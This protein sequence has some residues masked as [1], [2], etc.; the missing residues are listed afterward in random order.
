MKKLTIAVNPGDHDIGDVGYKVD[1][2]LKSCGL[3]NET[4]RAQ[5]LIVRELVENA[6]KYG[7]F[8]MPDDHLTVE[9]QVDEDAIIVEVMNPVTEDQDNNL[10][11]LDK[12]IRLIRGYQDPFEP[13]LMKRQESFDPIVGH[14]S[15]GLGLAKIAYQTG[16][17]LDYFISE[18]NMLN[19][20]AVKP[21]ADGPN[22]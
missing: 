16:A 11:I 14:D 5:V 9:L 19:V 2:F 18:D 21:L 4:I 1:Q 20:S 22:M 8:P 15:Q 13:Y 3:A 12:T 7:H 17:V 10:K 6:L